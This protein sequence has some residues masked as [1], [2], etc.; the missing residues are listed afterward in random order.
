[1]LFDLAGNYGSAPVIKSLRVSAA[2]TH[3]DHTLNTTGKSSLNMGWRPESFSF[4]ASAAS[5]TLSFE[6]LTAGGYGPVIDNVRVGA[7]PE[8]STWLM[9][10]GGLL[11]LAGLRARRILLRC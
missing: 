10:G 4:L 1:M 6:S 2:G 7:V 11:A 3:A 5:T 8:P 9:L